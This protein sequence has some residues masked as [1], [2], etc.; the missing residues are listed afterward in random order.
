MTTDSDLDRWLMYAE[1]H[2]RQLVANRT[3]TNIR[4][5]RR[6]FHAMTAQSDVMGRL[7]RNLLT[8]Y[9]AAEL[10]AAYNARC[11]AIVGR[12]VQR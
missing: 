2:A 4:Q 11:A 1:D 3:E 6:R 9:T 10:D 12:E 8:R 7:W 5:M